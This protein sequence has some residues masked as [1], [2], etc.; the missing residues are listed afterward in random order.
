MTVTQ[1]GITSEDIEQIQE[2]LDKP[3]YDQGPEDLAPDDQ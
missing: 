3:A 2:Y 1:V